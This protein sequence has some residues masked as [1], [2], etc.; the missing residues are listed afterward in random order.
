MTPKGKMDILNS[1]HSSDP[2]SE[3]SNH[4]FHVTFNLYTTVKGELINHPTKIYLS[5]IIREHKIFPYIL[6]ETFK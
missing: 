2:E 3:S 1:F 6:E 5:I 4:D